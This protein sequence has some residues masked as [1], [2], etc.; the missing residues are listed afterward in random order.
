MT[1]EQFNFNRSFGAR[2]KNNRKSFGLSQDDVCNALVPYRVVFVRESYSNIENGKR[3][4]TLFEAIAL[5]K[6]LNIDLS[7]YYAPAAYAAASIQ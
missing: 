7:S 2:C 1:I 6:V 4:V 3:S 5:A